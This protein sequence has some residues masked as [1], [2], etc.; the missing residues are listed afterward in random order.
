MYNISEYEAFVGRTKIMLV[1]QS[2]THLSRCHLTLPI[3]ICNPPMQTFFFSEFKVRLGPSKVN[4][5]LGNIFEENSVETITCSAQQPTDQSLGL[6]L[7]SVK[8]SLKP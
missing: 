7:N 8:T 3:T 4:E 6:S 5:I 1:K 2:D